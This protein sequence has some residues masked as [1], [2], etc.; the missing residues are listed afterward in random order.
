ME[1]AARVDPQLGRIEADEGAEVLRRRF[2]SDPD[3]SKV[4]AALREGVLG[5]DEELAVLRAVE[6]SE[7][8]EDRDE[9]L[10]RRR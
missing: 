1:V 7:L 4:D 6:L 9:G 10:L 2:V 5:G 3:H 8:G